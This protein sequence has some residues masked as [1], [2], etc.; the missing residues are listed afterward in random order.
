MSA[1]IPIAIVSKK[2]DNVSA[3]KKISIAKIE[4]PLPFK[5]KP[6]DDPPTPKLEINPKPVVV[7]KI[8]ISAIPIDKAIP[9]T[10]L[11]VEASGKQTIIT[12]SVPIV[13]PKQT[14]T[15]PKKLVITKKEPASKM[16]FKVGKK[17]IAGDYYWVEDTVLYPKKI[18]H[19]EFHKIIGYLHQ[20]S[21]V[22]EDESTQ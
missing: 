14:A 4:T 19:D 5:I 21:I 9:K 17:W 22:W 20:E 2:A 13:T 16:K 7:R 3:R 18:I 15:V 11:E 8:P 10:P 6:K 1:R 12:K